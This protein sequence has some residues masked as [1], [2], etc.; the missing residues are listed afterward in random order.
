[1]SFAIQV[2]LKLPTTIRY[3]M[4]HSHLTLS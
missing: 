4:L 3:S 1:M 2:H